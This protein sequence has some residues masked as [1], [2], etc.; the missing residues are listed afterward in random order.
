VREDSVFSCVYLSWRNQRSKPW[1][2]TRDL[3]E[4]LAPIG[5]RPIR[6]SVATGSFKLVRT[7]SLCKLPLTTSPNELRYGIRT[8]FLSRCIHKIGHNLKCSRNF[9]M[10]WKTPW[11]AKHYLSFYISRNIWNYLVFKARSLCEIERQKLSDGHLG[12]FGRCISFW[13][14]PVYRTR[15]EIHIH[16]FAFQAESD[17][18]CHVVY[19]GGGTYTKTTLVAGSKW[20]T[21]S[22]VQCVHRQ[23]D[24][25]M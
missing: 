4:C 6:A 18:H 22:C 7:C 23:W 12:N 16:S 2:I 24:L 13:D 11:S 5:R 15:N 9:F 17:K 19:T 21:V 20:Q 10:K 3:V 8:V 1:D 25:S 14:C